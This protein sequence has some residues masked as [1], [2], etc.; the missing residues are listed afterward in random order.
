MVLNFL[1]NCANGSTSLLPPYLVSLGA[2]Q[3]FVGVY[4]VLSVL[5]IV[6]TVVVFGKQLVRLPRVGAL[7]WG[8]VVTAGAYLLSWYFSGSLPLLVV[9][10][11]IGAVSQVF[12]STIMIAAVFESTPPGQRAG[13]LALFS[14]AGMLT[15]PMTSLL[16]ETLLA[17]FGGPSLFL[18]GAGFVLAA[19]VWSFLLRELPPLE[20][21]ETPSVFQV[22]RRPELRSL[23]VLTALFGIYYS[24]LLT[25]LPHHTMA[26][27]GQA[28]LSAFLVPFS[29][30]AVLMR[31]FVG[32]QFD[33]HPPRRFLHLSF[34]AIFVAMLCLLLPSWWALV[35]AGTLY[36]LG[37]SVLYPM[38]NSQVVQTG[39][40]DHKAAYSNAFTVVNLTSAVTMTPLLGLLGDFWGFGAIVTVLA[41]VAL[42]GFFVSRRSFPKPASGRPYGHNS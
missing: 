25:F 39:G 12:S 38:L 14:V 11:V 24:A 4:N 8:Y 30:V 31:V 29:I 42:A 35:V 20:R 37:H 5:M 19:F 10:R 41:V 27:L 34:F 33:R 22:Y 26:T 23:F 18:L 16:G 1:V 3:T 28:N 17:N 9:F 7:R 32:K 2:S 6:L 15:N 36:G 21:A 13:R 40:E